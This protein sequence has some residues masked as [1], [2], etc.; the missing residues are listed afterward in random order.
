[1]GGVRPGWPAPY[2][3]ESIRRSRRR[4]ILYIEMEYCKRTRDGSRVVTMSFNFKDYILR[5]C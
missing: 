4:N 5:I 2:L 3:V 1:M